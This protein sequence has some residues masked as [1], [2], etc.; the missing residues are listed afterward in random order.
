MCWS[1]RERVEGLGPYDVAAREPLFTRT[2][3]KT[4]IV[5]KSLGSTASKT[6]FKDEM[7]EA[8]NAATEDGQ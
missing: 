5:P 6:R 3:D 2:A 4:T 1:R 8:K 7:A